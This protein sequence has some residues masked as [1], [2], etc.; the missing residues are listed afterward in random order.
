MIL[1][2]SLRLL[3]FLSYEK[4][5]INFKEKENIL[6]DGASGSG[7]SSLIDAIVWC[8]YGEGRVGGKDLIRNGQ[9]EA[10]VDLTLRM[11]PDVDSKGEGEKEYTIT[12]RIT[13]SGKHT[14]GLY[15]DDK[16][17]RVSLPFSG[18]KESQA[19][20]SDTLV[21]A[22]YELF[23]NSV[24]YIQGAKESFV[25]QNSTR[26]KELLLE[27]VKAGTYDKMYDKARE[28]LQA[29]GS[30][31]AMHR[32]H[33]Q[34]LQDISEKL[35]TEITG[36]EDFTKNIKE[37]KE[38]LIGLE[39]IK[40]KT[41][42][43]VSKIKVAGE[44]ID[45]LKTNQERIIQRHREKE[46]ERDKKCEMLTKVN[47]WREVVKK[48]PEVE[49]TLKEMT[50]KLE[51]TIRFITDLNEKQIKKQ[52][53]IASIPRYPNLNEQKRIETHLERLAENPKC[54]AED[55]CP[56]YGSKKTEIKKLKKELEEEKQKD[57]D[58]IKLIEEL[59]EKAKQVDTSPLMMQTAIKDALESE[60]MEQKYKLDEITKI[61]KDITESEHLND[62][63]SELTIEIMHL[64]GEN[65]D[66]LE[67]IRKE[68]SLLDAGYVFEV[69]G[70][71]DKIEARIKLD[72]ETIINGEKYLEV[73]SEKEKQIQE[74]DDKIE[75]IQRQITQSAEV[76][77]KLE[78]IKDA[79][80]KKGLQTIVIDYMLPKLEDRTNAILSKMSDFS[81]RMDTQKPNATG[82]GVSEGLFITI[83]NPLGLELDYDSFSGGEKLKI[84]VAISEAL[85]T[86]QKV[87]FRL[88]D[89]VFVGLDTN[90]TE[91]FVA[92]LEELNKDFN[93]ILCISHL[94]E[95]KDLYEKKIT[96]TKANNISTIS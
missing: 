42:E 23:V 5:T 37:A 14:I 79:F 47:Q 21:G 78:L 35:K 54:P 46:I 89:E 56:Y 12:R 32:T 30:T 17:S 84:S 96:V 18:I 63:I 45:L 36:K 2:K 28:Q 70:R 7:K 60:V 58:T 48:R 6:I 15:M 8:L 43:E 4:T 90:S 62:E 34:L 75:V 72:T 92:V 64:N 67:Q 76:E 61:E 83:I 57:E 85:A 27:I 29:C 19:F 16:G 73:Y 49:A 11:L 65:N 41:E 26:R 13:R 66:V 93:Q 52:E 95:I 38:D 25:N 82:D 33:E 31:I 55:N 71:L 50:E 86:L 87:G 20:I 10:S 51:H 74:N 39:E 91:N 80:G 9:E 22:N 40:I 44:K 77:R 59:Q 3:N 69:E 88:F 81:I 68:E 24:A 1:L 53:I 94:E